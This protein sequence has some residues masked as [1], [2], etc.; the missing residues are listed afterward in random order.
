MKR[1]KFSDLLTY[2]KRTEDLFIKYGLKLHTNSRIKQYFQF[3][4]EI[5]LMR[6]ANK[7]EFGK[8][9]EKNQVKYYFSQHYVGEI[10]NIIESLESI[11]IDSNLIK[12]KLLKWSKGTYLL[13]EENIDDTSAR[14]TTFELDLFSFLNNLGIKT[15]FGEI[16]PD[17]ISSTSEYTYNIE[18]KR[19]ASL[20]SV[21][22]N[23]K[24]ALKQLRKPSNPTG[25]S[26]I[27][28]S[29]DKVLLD[30]DLIFHSKNE[31]QALESL[32]K[33]LKRF[34]DLNQNSI[35]KIVGNDSCV[36][37]YYLSIL[38]GFDDESLPMANARYMIGNV[39]NFNN[40][41]ILTDLSQFSGG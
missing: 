9:I 23:L 24:K 38:A 41:E 25:I 6:S 11:E 31:K 8:F 10:Q 13:S 5:E 16:N 39:Y 15:R 18:C 21:E 22:R 20:K 26:T 4:K 7:E 32:E 28:L 30:D 36:I 12:E 40:N 33:I 19:P 17:L 14:N 1:F 35:R 34:M 2:E 37:F 29:L 27:A 3:L